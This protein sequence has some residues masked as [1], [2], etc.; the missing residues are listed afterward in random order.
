[1]KTCVNCGRE[2]PDEE[3]CCP[4]CGVRPDFEPALLANIA[5]ETELGMAAELLEQAGIP[6]YAKKR[7]N[8]EYLQIVLGRTMFGTELYVDRREL[9]RAKDVIGVLGGEEPFDEAALEQAVENC[10]AQPDEPPARGNYRMF[11]WFL[12]VFGLFILLVLLLRALS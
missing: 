4:G 3:P 8:G 2:Y 5:D 1:M 7:E 9:E 6:Y 12:A 10:P 11:I